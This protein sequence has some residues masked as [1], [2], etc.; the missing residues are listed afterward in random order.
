MATYPLGLTENTS[1]PDAFFTN[2]AE[3]DE[4]IVVVAEVVVVVAEV[5]VVVAEVVVVVV[6]L[7]HSEQS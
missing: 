3:V 5:V 2:S 1:V 4:G 7:L 6:A